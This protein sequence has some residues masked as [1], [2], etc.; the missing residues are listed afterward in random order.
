MEPAGGNWGSGKR[1]RTP[2]GSVHRTRLSRVA[3]FI[4]FFVGGDAQTWAGPICRAVFKPSQAL[5]L[6]SDQSCGARWRGSRD[7][8]PRVPSLLTA[9]EPLVHCSGHRN[10]WRCTTF[11]NPK[12]SRVES[13][14]NPSPLDYPHCNHRISLRCNNMRLGNGDRYVEFLPDGTTPNTHSTHMSLR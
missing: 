12:A 2:Y 10:Q 3:A 11:H 4:P 13:N 5:H 14:S 9:L 1:R 7:R 8:L 6:P